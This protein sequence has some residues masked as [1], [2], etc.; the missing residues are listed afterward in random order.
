MTGQ[1]SMRKVFG[2]TLVNLADKYPE[3]VVLDADVSNS[4]QTILFGKKYPERFFNV[5]VSESNMV[6][7]AGGMATCGLLPVV[8][9]FAIFLSLK[10]AEQIRNIV[11]Y[12][13][14]PVILAGGY[15]GLSD[16]FDGASHQSVEDVAIL[17]SLPNMNILVPADYNETGP[18]LEYAI[19][20]R[21]PVYLRL[22][23]NPL[24]SLF[25]EPGTC[26]DFKKIRH[27]RKGSDLTIAVCGAPCY[28][29]VQAAK[30][31]EKESVSIDLLIVSSLKPFDSE[32][33]IRSVSRTRRLLIIDEH[34]IIG[35]LRSA[36]LENIPTEIQYKSD[37]IGIEDCF[38]ETGEYFELLRKFGFSVENIIYKAKKLIELL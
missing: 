3:I 33:I 15:A 5:G 9:T 6:D 22:L 29:A 2:E 18:A 17:R 35:G 8:S 34:N 1:E 4:T 36:I 26:F 11:C 37:F 20:L 19:S 24:P 38:G 23:R 12:N 31:L 27:L 13:N 7:L 16:S 21:A 32:T 25:D 14:L 30:E 10:G 28:M